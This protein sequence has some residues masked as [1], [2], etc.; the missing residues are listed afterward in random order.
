L[1]RRDL[2]FRISERQYAFILSQIQATDETIASYIRH[3][4]HEAMKHAA[5]KDGT[6]SV[7]TTLRD[8]HA[9]LI[10]QLQRRMQ[11]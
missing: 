10:S 7:P 5:E 1:T 11:V 8:Q 3:L 9:S 4:V 2:H 6:G